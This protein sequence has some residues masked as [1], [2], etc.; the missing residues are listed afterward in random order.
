M[1]L[2]FFLRA[3]LFVLA[4]SVLLGQTPILQATESVE[5]DHRVIETKFVDPLSSVGYFSRTIDRDS[6]LLAISGASVSGREGAHVVFKTLI[7]AGNRYAYDPDLGGW[8]FQRRDPSPN[9]TGYLEP[10]EFGADPFVRKSLEILNATRDTDLLNSVHQL[11]FPSGRVVKMS[12]L[13]LVPSEDDRIY[14]LVGSQIA[15]I[16]TLRSGK[17]VKVVKNF[18][19]PPPLSPDLFKVPEIA[20]KIY[21]AVFEQRRFGMDEDEVGGFIW[22]RSE[23]KLLVDGV[24][25]KANALRSGLRPG[26]EITG[27]NG[28]SVIDAGEGEIAALLKMAGD[29]KMEVVHE[30]RAASLVVKRS[31]LGLLKDPGGLFKIIRRR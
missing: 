24:F 26:D 1:R 30:G 19:A 27:L 15:S 21:E 31:K 20:S 28:K 2:Y 5:D 18:I 23:G 16:T 6:S 11:K 14:E 8:L 10:V 12:D 9:L 7:I 3:A 4:P 22:R 29:L 17:P 13:H 25:A